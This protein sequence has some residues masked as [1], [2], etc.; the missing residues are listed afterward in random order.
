MS[1]ASFG[2][3]EDANRGYGAQAHFKNLAKALG[4]PATST[5]T[6]EISKQAF[7]QLDEDC[8]G[9]VDVTELIEWCFKNEVFGDVGRPYYETT[10]RRLFN[11]AACGADGLTGDS[12]YEFVRGIQKEDIQLERASRHHLLEYPKSLKK[13]NAKN[14]SLAEIERQ[15]HQKIMQGTTRDSDRARHIATMF[16]VQLQRD[17]GEVDD[18]S[19]Q[20]GTLSIT[21]P[22]FRKVLNVLG[23]FSTPEQADQLFE[24]YDINGD[25]DLTVHE[26]LTKAYPDDYPGMKPLDA[27]R[28]YDWRLGGAGK[29]LFPDE[30]IGARPITPHSAVFTL[31]WSQM[32]ATIRNKIKLRERSGTAV[33]IPNA[34]RK[35]AQKFEFYDP[36]NLGC[37]TKENLEKALATIGITYG[38]SHLSELMAKCP[39]EDYPEDAEPVFDYVSFCMKVYPLEAQE[40]PIQTSLVN[41]SPNSAAVREAAAA[42]EKAARSPKGAKLNINSTGILAASGAQVL[43]NVNKT[44]FYYKPTSPSGQANSMNTDRSLSSRLSHQMRMQT[45]RQQSRS[46]SRASTQEW[47]TA[48]LP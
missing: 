13:T 43:S 26:F 17:S 45:G 6:R 8:S 33:S 1:V 16:K 27:S 3:S 39:P 38:D 21:K 30:G 18:E 40:T 19:V 9:S 29:R 20:D 48:V 34:R 31:N 37:V 7:K 12:F 25:G 11:D 41:N 28:Y 4:V 15:L 36:Q 46:S 2:I 32:A 24:K 22:Q 42:A 35:L 14:F 23:L 10:C 5:I 44:G 47:R